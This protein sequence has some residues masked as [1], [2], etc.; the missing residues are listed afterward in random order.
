M[1]RIIPQCLVQS[2]ANK[3]V[4]VKSQQELVG[5]F[6]SGRFTS[7]KYNRVIIMLDVPIHR[8]YNCDH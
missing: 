4:P 5:D 6:L 8:G 3:I 1:R 7:S 2:S